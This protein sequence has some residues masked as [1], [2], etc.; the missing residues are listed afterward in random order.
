MSTLSWQLILFWRQ[1]CTHVG[2]S[3]GRIPWLVVQSCHFL[4][5]H[6]WAQIVE[7]YKYLCYPALPSSSDF[8][9]GWPPSTCHLVW[10]ALY[11]PGGVNVLESPRRRVVEACHRLRGKLSS[12]HMFGSPSSPITQES[13]RLY[14]ENYSSACVVIAQ[15]SRLRFALKVFA[16]G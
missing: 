8:H 14:E 11:P 15:D 12:Y 7:E 4:R 2:A 10:R 16:L 13:R 1:T 9:V 5:G 6:L 3:Q